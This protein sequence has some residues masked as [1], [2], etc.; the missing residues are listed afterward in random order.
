[1]QPTVRR[2]HDAPPAWHP[3]AEDLGYVPGDLIDGEDDGW[4]DE[5][6]RTAIDA[7][8]YAVPLAM[9]LWA[10]IIWG[11][12]AAWGQSIPSVED[13]GPKAKDAQL[14][15]AF[16]GEFLPAPLVDAVVRQQDLAYL[17]RVVAWK[18]PNPPPMTVGVV[19]GKAFN[20]GCAGGVYLAGWVLEAATRVQ[21]R[22]DSSTIYHEATVTPTLAGYPDSWTW[23]V[24]PLYHDG[25]A[26]GVYARAIRA[27][28]TYIGPLDNA[29]SS[30]RYQFTIPAGESAPN[31]LPPATPPAFTSGRVS[32]AA[33]VVTIE[34]AP[35]FTRVELLIDSRD[36][37]PWYQ[38]VRTLVDG[39]AT[40]TLPA[41]ARDGAEHLLDVR[42]YDPAAAGVFRP[43]GYPT[44]AVLAP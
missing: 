26:H 36:V 1:M 5:P 2:H 7:L 9:V 27:T 8:R 25:K 35:R 39:K 22:V 34:A 19:I 43:D 29:K 10:L 17:E 20:P 3:R 21:I 11:I 12:S 4:Y 40:F 42:L 24:P 18:K 6:E 13:T 37:A 14:G 15:V 38:G 16:A 41:A 28:G 23:C 31:P 32:Y 44:K 33:G 30:S